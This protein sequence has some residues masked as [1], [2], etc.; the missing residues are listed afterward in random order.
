MLKCRAGLP[1]M[2]LVLIAFLFFARGAAAVESTCP[3]AVIATAT[4][5]RGQT[6]LTVYSD[7]EKTEKLGRLKKGVVCEVVGVSGSYYRVRFDGIDG[8]AP[9]AKLSLK[10]AAGGAARAEGAAGQLSL[11]QYLYA[12]P[13]QAKS[14][15]PRGA[16]Q[17][18]APLDT[19]FFFVWDERLQ[20]VE[21]LTAMAVNSPDN[22]LELG[23]VCPAVA[24]PAMTAGRKT[25]LAQGASDGRLMELG[26]APLYVCG[27]FRAVRNINDQCRFSAGKNQDQMA[28]R[29]W[30]PAGEPLTITLPAD[31]SAAL[32]TI[33]WRAPTA[34]TVT[35][36][37]ED[38]R[39]IAEEARST[40][41]YADAVAFPEGTRQA[42]LAVT[43]QD[44]WVRNLCVYDANHPDSAVQQW[45][46]LPD[47]LDLLV[48]SPHQDDELLF[49][50]GAIPDACHR[51]A[52]VGVVYMTYCGRSRY[53]EALDGLWTAGLRCHPIFLNWQDQWGHNVKHALNTWSQNGVD[54]Q[55]EVVRLIRK[56]RPEVVLGPDPEGEYG[57]AQ[58]QLT[59][60]LVAAAIP[61]AMDEGYDPESAAQ[62]GV[63]EVRK[64]YLH[65]YAENRIEL[66][67]DRPFS[68]DSP[69]SPMFLAR[70]AFDKH[71]SQQGFSMNDEA[72][73]YD[74]RIFGL[75]YTAVGPDEAGNDLFE[76]ITTVPGRP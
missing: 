11:A 24:F 70:E 58:H 28:G 49:Y 72:V 25:L 13:A 17:A 62:Y 15:S 74:N 75:F 21:Q 48:F 73:R 57:H 18:D 4:L 38:Q 52:D 26:R 20:Q 76:H 9:A 40:G 14:L 2:L 45:E 5:A 34:F 29:S 33:E 37:D 44:P 30:T 60:Q 36:L 27:S 51:G 7:T 6:E 35:F 10:G 65:L 1:A 41:F 12:S 61:L 67:W 55:R 8:Y 42:R 16:F 19:L 47:K 22:R 68:T 43:G 54:P 39:V 66:D 53:S 3:P 64:A 56:Y 69:I 46:P 32:M 23:D 31:G 59:S 63:W 50:G 71:R